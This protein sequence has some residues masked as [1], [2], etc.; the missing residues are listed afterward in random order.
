M[1]AKLAIASVLATIVA[2][3]RFKKAAKAD[4][5]PVVVP[6]PEEEEEACETEFDA[7][8]VTAGAVSEYVVVARPRQSER[9]ILG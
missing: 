7:P 3:A 8:E 2:V 1:I 9:R 4:S 5:E 6:A